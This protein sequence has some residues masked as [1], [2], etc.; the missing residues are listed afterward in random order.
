M[1]QEKD[2]VIAFL[3]QQ[4][5]ALNSSHPN[6]AS[7]LEVAALRTQLADTRAQLA[8]AQAQ[9]SRPASATNVTPEQLARMENMMQ[10]M[11]KA[12]TQALLVRQQQPVQQAQQPAAVSKED[13][14]AIALA[15]DGHTPTGDTDDESEAPAP[16]PARVQ[17][18][19]NQTHAAV[20]DAE[21]KAQDERIQQ[22]LKLEQ[23]R[24]AAQRAGTFIFHN[25][26]GFWWDSCSQFLCC[27]LCRNSCRRP[28]RA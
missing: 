12:L 11:Q 7:E 21:R 2:A 4:N 28:S 1:R 18:A 17:P 9:H 19:S 6:A 8:Q 27:C 26:F 22:A 15:I 20:V 16:A 23:E 24:E 10:D 14:K 25:L 3:Q 5:K 13:M